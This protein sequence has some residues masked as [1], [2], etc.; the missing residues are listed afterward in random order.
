MAARGRRRR[1][2]A[3]RLGRNEFQTAI[4]MAFVSRN[5]EQVAGEARRGAI[6][7]IT[8]EDIIEEI[9]TEEIHDEADREKAL[10]TVAE[11]RQDRQ[12]PPASAAK[13]TAGGLPQ[14]RVSIHGR[15]GRSRRHNAVW[16]GPEDV[17][18][19]TFY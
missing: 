18:L 17:T 6:G 4:H 19:Y 2:T 16:V 15:A 10:E 8:L 14:R 13:R 3:A 12:G 7:I 5:I 1:H 9:L 11:H